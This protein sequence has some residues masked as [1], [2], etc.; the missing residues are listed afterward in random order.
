LFLERDGERLSGA[1]SQPRRL[2]LLALLASAGEHGMTR[3][4]I[5]GMLWAESDE[6]RAR[7]GLNQALYALRQEIGADEVFLGTRDIRLNPDLITSDIAAFTLA[8]KAGRLEQAAAEYIGPFLDGFHIS[9][10]PEFERWLEEERAGLARDYA[11]MLQRLARRAGEDGSRA[12]AA[13]WWRKLAAQDPLNARVAIGLM[14]ALVAAGD[15]SSA[16]HHARVYEVLLQQ[17]LEAPPDAEVVALAARIREQAEAPAQ[18]RIDS[19]VP[20]ATS[21]AAPATEPAVVEAEVRAAPPV[22][23][24]S[25]VVESGADLPAAPASVAPTPAPSLPP[26]RLA[27]EPVGAPPA[28]TPSARWWWL[29][30]AAILAGVSFA[31]FAAI[32]QSGAPA[33][34]HVGRIN[35][36]TAEPGLEVHPSLSPDGKFLA[37]AAGPTGRLR[38]YVRQLDGGRTI[39]V[40]EDLG[41]D[42]HWP[43]WSPDGTRLSLETNRSIYLVP[44]LGGDPKLL[45]APAAGPQVNG[46]GALSDEGPSYLAWSPDGRRIAYAVGREI[47][48]RAVSGGPVTRLAAMDQ[49]HSFAWSPDGTRLAL[50]VGNSAF[51]YA[52]DAIGNIAPSSI[53]IV[54]TSGG[55]PE[56]VT[57]AASLNTCP[58][59]MPDGRSLLFISN[60]DG[61]RD[62][63]RVTLGRSGGPTA[64]PTRITTGLNLHG[65]DLS[66]DGRVLVYADFSDYANIRSLNLPERGTIS[67]A[68]STALTSGH[69]SIEGLALSPDGRW[70]AFD[71]DRGGHQAIY[72]LALPGGE[73]QLLSS[74]SDDDFMP[75]WS[76]DGRELAYYGFRQG[77]RRLFVMPIDGGAPGPVARDSGNQRYPG[78]AP[79][80]KQLV[81]HSDRTGRF[82]LYV[83]AR[84]PGGR[85]S[86]PRQ[87]TTEG[88]QDARWSPDGGS[89]LYLR[90][91]RLWVIPA[92]GGAPRL[93]VAPGDSLQRPLLAQW[94]PDG[95]TVYYKEQDAHGAT[96]LWA[97]ATAG[98]KPRELVR[99]DDPLRTSSRA[100]FATDGQRLFFTASERESDIWR[101]ELE[102]R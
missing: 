20:Q 64:V 40:A 30:A 85:W 84:D 48:V 53:W 57:D 82:E 5:L 11:S 102:P 61:S 46:E 78:W 18:I 62:I 90:D 66:R 35:R 13:E 56:R 94:A 72:R 54:P 81:F 99:F 98:G 24:G 21:Q 45:V 15:R 38:I 83:V 27:P 50:V 95:R 19:P 71:S 67:S 79:D 14:E 73:P 60:R 29:V 41:G 80:G 76:P 6:D 34:L 17:E 51:V 36:L 16:L 59:W 10:A 86:R 77:H 8:V 44:A 88:G 100:E 22:P 58:A 23:A 55:P 52:P 7:R 93:L 68:V 26:S 96:S 75:A 47:E 3:D 65:L 43:R 25:Q 32:H 42:Q 39:A 89:I 9:E 69:Q 1:A 97:I 74:D 70:L 2:A 31:G 49:P 101:M 33:S 4:R 92:G 37:F 63:Y 91:A 28:G 87:L 12:E